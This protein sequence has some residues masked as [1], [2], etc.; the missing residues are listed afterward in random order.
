MSFLSFLFGQP[1]EIVMNCNQIPIKFEVLSCAFFLNSVL[2]LLVQNQK[3]SY[4]CISQ[5]K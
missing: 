5:E 4:E 3:E 1:R 2:D